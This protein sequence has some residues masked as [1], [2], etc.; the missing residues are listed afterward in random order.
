M[1]DRGAVPGALHELEQ[2]S[3][4]QLNCEIRRCLLAYASA[5]GMRRKEFFKQL[6][7]AETM[8][9][10]LHDIPAPKRARCN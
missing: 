8:R 5:A 1:D 7:W 6:V 2:H 9:A 4:Q 3:L 10:R